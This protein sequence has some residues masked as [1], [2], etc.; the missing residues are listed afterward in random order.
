MTDCRLQLAGP[1][2]VSALF[3]PA[4]FRLSLSATGRGTV[5]AGAV[6]LVATA[7]RPRTARLVSYE[8]VRRVAR[9]AKGW[10]FGGRVGAVPMTRDTAVR[11]MFV[12]LR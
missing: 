6:G 8:P 3:A 9:P 4:R 2:A 1:T 11:A 7:A 5:T 10:R 12:R